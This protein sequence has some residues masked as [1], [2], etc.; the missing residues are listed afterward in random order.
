MEFHRA[1]Q[2]KWPIASESLSISLRLHKGS[3]ATIMGYNIGII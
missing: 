3:E 1:P 2:D